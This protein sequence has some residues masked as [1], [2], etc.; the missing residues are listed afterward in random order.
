M[1]TSGSEHK[2]SSG[3]QLKHP[4]PARGADRVDKTTAEDPSKVSYAERQAKRRAAEVS[5]NF[6][7]IELRHKRKSLRKKGGWGRNRAKREKK[8]AYNAQTAALY[9]GQ[10]SEMN[11]S[12]AISQNRRHHF[13]SGCKISTSSDVI[14]QI[15][16]VELGIDNMDNN[17]SDVTSDA[18]SNS[19]AALVVDQDNVLERISRPNA[20]KTNAQKEQEAKDISALPPSRKRFKQRHHSSVNKNVNGKHI[21]SSAVPKNANS[22]VVQQVVRSGHS[23]P[24][25]WTVKKSGPNKGRKFWSCLWS[26][27][28]L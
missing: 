3:Y 16:D 13:K 18:H 14:D 8:K 20:T 27:W 12:S 25:S 28:S 26:R 2:A 19:N 5:T 6:V 11:P 21:C 24:A 17:M 23:L 4:L 7:R 10:P 15:L 22:A 9:G 1:H